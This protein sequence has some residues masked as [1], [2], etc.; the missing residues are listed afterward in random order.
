VFLLT[1]WAYGNY[2][3][4]AATPLAPTAGTPPPTNL[5]PVNPDIQPVPLES[6]FPY[7][8][9]THTAGIEYAPE[10]RLRL[11]LLGEYFRN[12]GLSTLARQA[13]PLQTGVKVGTQGNYNLTHRDGLVVSLSA[14]RTRFSTGSNVLL[15]ENLQGWQRQLTRQTQAQLSAGISALKSS[16]Q[17]VAGVTPDVWMYYPGAMVTVNHNVPLR[18]QRLNFY[19]LAQL[20]PI[21]DRLSGSAY[22]RAEL[23]GNTGYG[24]AENWHL[25]AGAGISRSLSEGPNEGDRVVSASSELTYRFMP[26]LAALGGFR[27]SWQRSQAVGP[28]TQFLWVATVALTYQERFHTQP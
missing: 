27:A 1:D 19:G 13:I 20:G 18:D 23:Q 24:F 4:A 11:Q 6:G 22:Q 14:T 3:F 26:Q 12:G 10:R 5:P 28:E 15:L 25:A 17:V 8:N 2:Q 7:L 9:L 16:G 21:I